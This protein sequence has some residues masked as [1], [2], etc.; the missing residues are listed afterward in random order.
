[1]ATFV[2]RGQ[3]TTPTFAVSLCRGSGR[4]TAKCTELLRVTILTL[5]ELERGC[6]CPAGMT[7]LVLFLLMCVYVIQELKS[8]IAWFLQEAQETFVSEGVVCS[9]VLFVRVN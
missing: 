1:M 5:F 9:S 6:I 4:L 3:K 7:C 8:V 2:N